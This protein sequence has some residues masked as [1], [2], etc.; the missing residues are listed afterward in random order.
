VKINGVQVNIPPPAEPEFNFLGS[1]GLLFTSDPKRVSNNTF[2]EEVDLESTS[3]PSSNI[4]ITTTDSDD[5]RTI[6]RY[7]KLKTQFRWTSTD[8]NPIP[9]DVFGRQVHSDILAEQ[10]GLGNNWGAM[11]RN[12][13]SNPSGDGDV[14]LLTKITKQRISTGEI[15][16]V[17][18]IRGLMANI[19]IDGGD[20]E[21]NQVA[22]YAGSK[23]APM[24]MNT[25]QIGGVEHTHGWYGL[26]FLENNRF[27]VRRLAYYNSNTWMSAICI[28]VHGYI[29]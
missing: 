22:I 20:T 29:L 17:Q 24:F 18:R 25:T 28:F 4:V 15:L 19:F 23:N 5:I 27:F 21:N 3:I 6:K 11:L 16:S 26:I 13:G 10:Y 2:D 12:R 7:L 14:L 9:T 8:G 1:A